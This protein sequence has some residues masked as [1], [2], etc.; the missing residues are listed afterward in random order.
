MRPM[1]LECGL[2]ARC[3]CCGC[4]C[5]CSILS[6]SLPVSVIT[7]MNRNWKIFNEAIHLWATKM[8]RGEGERKREKNTL[9][10]ARYFRNAH[11]L[12]LMMC[13]LHTAVG[14]KQHTRW[15]CVK[16]ETQTYISR[17]FHINMCTSFLFSSGFP[18]MQLSIFYYS[19]RALS[20]IRSF[21]CI[22][23]SELLL[24]LMNVQ[25]WHCISYQHSRLQVADCFPFKTHQN[26]L[27][28]TNDFRI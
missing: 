4:C 9:T 5:F 17:S 13:A 24:W 1:E 28:W 7:A 6:L 2:I 19:E 15:E 18:S 14:S 11:N 20:D 25:R 12:K 26:T 16:H 27:W 22:W 8:V 21:A 23:K 10:S 3:G